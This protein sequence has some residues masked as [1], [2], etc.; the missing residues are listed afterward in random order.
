M[1]V[2]A[3]V[4]D[5]VVQAEREQRVKV[6]QVGDLR[7]LF[8]QFWYTKASVEVETIQNVPVSRVLDPLQHG[9]PCPAR[10]FELMHRWP[11]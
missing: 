3:L 6:V 9:F 2:E 11:R 7:L 5:V 4:D 10:E 8:S 1:L